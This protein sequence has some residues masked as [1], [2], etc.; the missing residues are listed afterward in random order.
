[1][2]MNGKKYPLAVVGRSGITLGHHAGFFTATRT[3]MRA[4]VMCLSGSN[5]ASRPSS[6]RGERS[7]L[8]NLRLSPNPVANGPNP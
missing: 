6:R 4:L 8:V 5:E 1:M 3:N 7:R 2:L